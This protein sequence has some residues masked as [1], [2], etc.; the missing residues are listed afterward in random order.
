MR[1]L[2]G[3]A[4]LRPGRRPE[5]ERH[6]AEPPDA[7][8]PE[9]SPSTSGCRTSSAAPRTTSSST[10]NCGEAYGVVDRELKASSPTSSGRSCRRRCRR[11]PTSTCRRITRPRSGPAATTTTSSR[12]PTAR[13][14]LMIA[15]VGGHGTPAA[16]MMAITHS[17]AHAFPGPPDP[18]GRMLDVRQRASRARY[19]TEGETFVTAFYAD[20][21][22]ESRTLTYANA[23]H[24]PPRL[25][26]C[27]DGSIACA[28]RRRRPAAGRLP[29]QAYEP[30]D[31]RAA[32]RRPDHLLHRRHHRGRRPR[33]RTCSVSTG[34]TRRWRT[35]SSTP[36][37]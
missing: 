14:G 18:P 10:S 24:N 15:D 8:D 36:R 12:C 31:L 11:S 20:L 22:P 19:T 25:K 33:R 7:F 37:G 5:H 28:R 1:S 26:R 16:V 3:R 23:G 29:G 34:S 30:G 21:R 2:A 6:P 17:L 35:A 9:G 32:P 27:E 4:E 13:W